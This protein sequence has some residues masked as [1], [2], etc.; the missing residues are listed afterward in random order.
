MATSLATD[1]SVK[2]GSGAIVNVTASTLTLTAD[3]HAGKTITINA[4]SGCAV[5]LAAATGTNDVYRIIIGTTISS[6]STTLTCAGSDKLYGIVA[7]A[8]TTGGT[9]NE[10]QDAANGSET[11]ITMNGGTTGGIVGSFIQLRDFATN[12]WLIEAAQLVGSGSLATS[13]S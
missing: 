8:T 13:L 12:K 4:A 3:V 5:T 2:G 1:G 10:F 9:G 11:V 7:T 6:N